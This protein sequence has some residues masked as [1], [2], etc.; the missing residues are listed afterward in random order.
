MPRIE[1]TPEN[2]GDKI[3]FRIAC[4]WGIERGPRIVRSVDVANQRCTVRLAGCNDFGINFDEITD[5]WCNK[6]KLHL[7]VDKAAAANASGRRLWENLTG[8]FMG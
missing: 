5:L 7:A 2:V 4:R 3:D 8:R 6:G 1:L